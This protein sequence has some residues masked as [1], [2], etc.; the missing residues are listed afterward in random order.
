MMEKPSA[1]RRIGN[2]LLGILAAFVILEPIWM[3]LPFAG[4]LYGSVFQIQTL[5]RNPDTAWLTHFVFP[6]L[7]LG[8]TGPILAISGLIVFFAGAFQ[9]YASKLRRTGLVTSGLYG[10]VRHPQYIALTMFGIGILLTWGRAIAFI[11]FFFMMFL[12]YVLAR[13]EEARCRRLFGEAYERYRE[14]SSFVFPG[15]RRLPPPP[16]RGLSSP[17]RIVLGLLLTAGLCFG[18]MAGVRAVK[19]A[20][21]TVPFLTSTVALPPPP[22]AFADIRSGE[23]GG[24]PYVSRGRIAVVRGP[25]RNG[26]APGFAERAVVAIEQSPRLQD[27]VAAAGT[28]GAV[29]AFV[30]PFDRKGGPPPQSDGGRRGPPVD[31]H[32][33]DRA[34]L[35]VF[36]S[37]DA[38]PDLDR[39]FTDPA[40]IEWSG[41]CFARVDLA[42]P[43]AED[44]IVEKPFVPG[45]KFRAAEKWIDLVDQVGKQGRPGTAGATGHAETPF[46]LV[47]APILRLRRDP[48]FAEKVRARLTASSRLSAHLSAAG[49]GPMTIPVAF[50]RPGPD[51]Y[52]EHHH[53]ARLSVFVVLVRPNPGATPGEI[54]ENRAR[55]ILSAFIAE[56]DL[57][58]VAPADAVTSIETIGFRRD[59]EERWDF[60]LSGL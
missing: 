42:A 44:P 53:D 6:V 16:F 43:A 41:A 26:A 46:L 2:V 14:R 40:G 9:I 38:G 54:L 20:M 45:P 58:T 28:G 50:P 37:P 29:A 49:A 18:S 31:P 30:L 22:P 35:F 47:K 3:L 27:R 32:G 36:S 56:T 55:T 60:F 17:V 7:T 15:D 59:I 51:W 10:F 24:V 5:S 57:A 13:V 23:A 8:F 48:A 12:Y 39:L 4:F 52:R 11:A 25:Y 33:P 21:R 34:T 19:H 1:V